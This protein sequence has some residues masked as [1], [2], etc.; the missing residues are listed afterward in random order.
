[1]ELLLDL[2]NF[3]QPYGTYSYVLMFVVLLACGFGFPMP[4]DVV[5]VTGGILAA[6]GITDFW[7]TNVV[8][9]AG[10]LIGDGT[11][12]TI[13]R[14]IGHRVKQ[15]WLFRRLVSPE[16]DERVD[17][18]FSRW[19]DR[20]VFVARFMPGLRTPIFLTAG[21]YRIKYRKF[22]ALD[23]SAA[24]ISVP[25]WIWLGELF[26][27]NLELLYAKMKQMQA[28]VLASLVVIIIAGIII[29]KRRRND[30]VEDRSASRPVNRTESTMP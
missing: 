2:L 10:V 21:I 19:G 13:G 5:L 30:V 25:V 23:G 17:R 18:V 7:M 27:D 1:M 20:V 22:F 11:V 4:E 14:L 28:G 26:G 24:L 6:R 8:C 3:L 12:F 16:M 29:Y 9:M 15:T